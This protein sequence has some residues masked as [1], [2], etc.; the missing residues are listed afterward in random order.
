MTPKPYSWAS[1][2]LDTGQIPP[3]KMLWE[4]MSTPPPS[5]STLHTCH[6]LLPSPSE[7]LRRHRRHHRRDVLS[8]L[9]N[10]VVTVTTTFAANGKVDTRLPSASAIKTRSANRRLRFNRMLINR[11]VI[12]LGDSCDFYVTHLLNARELFIDLFEVNSLHLLS[13]SLTSRIFV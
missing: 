8:V 12:A 6:P 11:E 7:R 13:V 1:E 5:P 3:R 9:A 2:G 10:F 4:L